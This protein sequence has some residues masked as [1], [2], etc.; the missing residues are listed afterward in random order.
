MSAF[1]HFF[2]RVNK[3]YIKECLMKRCC[4]LIC[5]L[6]FL[7]M[8]AIPCFIVGSTQNRTQLKTKFF[9]PTFIKKE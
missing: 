6:V 4:L 5:G 3:T 2:S 1:T 7:F 9:T 8:T